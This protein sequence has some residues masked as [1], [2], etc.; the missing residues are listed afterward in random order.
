MIG[1]EL[2]GRSRLE[3]SPVFSLSV[4]FAD[5]GGKKGNSGDT[6]TDNTEQQIE[7]CVENGM[8]NDGLL[9]KVFVPKEA[10]ESH[11]RTECTIEILELD[12]PNNDD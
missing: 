6:S 12:E 2:F 8:D 10:R 9:Q 11:H 5:T 1:V 7:E 3:N 4:C